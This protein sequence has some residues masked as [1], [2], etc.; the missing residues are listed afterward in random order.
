MDSKLARIIDG[1]ETSGESEAS[2]A[3][4]VKEYMS[5]SPLK[6]TITN[7]AKDYHEHGKD[8]HYEDEYPG[9]PDTW[10]TGEESS[11]RLHPEAENRVWYDLFKGNI[12]K[13]DWDPAPETEI[14]FGG[15]TL[16]KKSDPKPEP[17][18]E[19]RSGG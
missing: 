11:A 14:K 2:I 17:E 10:S 7:L 18:P 12:G 13:K 4:V 9:D 5:N 1:M 8:T 6:H 3:N 15:F 16:G 19:P